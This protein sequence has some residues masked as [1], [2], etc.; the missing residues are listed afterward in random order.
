MRHDDSLFVAV[1]ARFRD[2]SAFGFLL[3]LL[4]GILLISVIFW[5]LVEPPAPWHPQPVV[6]DVEGDNAESPTCWELERPAWLL[7]ALYDPEEGLA[8]SSRQAVTQ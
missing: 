5:L 6:Y 2:G 7:K 4:I 1:L 8:C 3:G